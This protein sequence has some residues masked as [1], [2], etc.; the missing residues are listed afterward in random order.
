V[1]CSWPDKG[2]WQAFS[3]CPADAGTT[4]SE[5]DERRPVRHRDILRIRAHNGFFLAVPSDAARGALVTTTRSKTCKEAEF[6][7]LL[8]HSSILKH[9]GMAYFF[10]R[11]T[12]TTLD[13][14][15]DESGMRARW[16]DFGDWQAIAVE[17]PAQQQR[18]VCL[19]SLQQQAPPRTRL[20]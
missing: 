2:S 17:R 12:A 8:Q 15:E 9:R 19:D 7:V 5:K 18:K 16:A 4:T 20:R 14:D 10:S 1:D 11:A 6:E 3:F 13:A